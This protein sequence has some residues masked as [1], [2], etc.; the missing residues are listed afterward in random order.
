MGIRGMV[1]KYKTLKKQHKL[2]HT[3]KNFINLLIITFLVLNKQILAQAPIFQTGDILMSAMAISPDG[4]MIAVEGV[5]SEIAIWDMATRKKTTVLKRNK[6][7]REGEEDEPQMGLAMSMGSGKSGKALF[8]QSGQHLIACHEDGLV[9]WNLKQTNP[10]LE[11][12]VLPDYFDVSRDGNFVAFIKTAILEEDYL[13]PARIKGKHTITDTILVLNLKENKETTLVIE[14]NTI[15]RIRFS[16]DGLSLFMISADGAFIAASVQSGKVTDN[17]SIYSG[18]DSEESL[19]Y[20]QSD[21]TNMFSSISVAAHPKQ[22]LI[23]ATDANKNLYIY[24]YLRHKVKH[25]LKIEPGIIPGQNFALLQF[26]SNGEYLLGVNLVIKNEGFS[27]ILYFWEVESGKLSK[28]FDL[29]IVS[30]ISFSPDGQWLALS[31]MDVNKNPPFIISVY[32]ASTLSETES[33]PGRGSLCF[34][35]KENKKLA[36]FAKNGIGIYN[37]K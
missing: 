13:P 1:E 25:K 4:K 5:S 7:K 21:E 9:V 14:S 12:F 30:D 20:P 23:A 34:F 10:V 6:R 32:N 31:R 36:Y 22:P 37:L 33:F 24:D 16:S 26:T 18:G 19:D 3:M 8:S 35:P 15:K 27:K 11:L 28:S 29:G 17:A 2:Y